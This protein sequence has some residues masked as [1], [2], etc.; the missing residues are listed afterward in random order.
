MG[1][2]G[3]VEWILNNRSDESCQTDY[4]LNAD[5]VGL[6]ALYAEITGF[7]GEEEAIDFL[8]RERMRELA[9]RQQEE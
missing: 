2:W 6:A 3:D 9:E 4:R 8:V 7:D 1:R 5:T